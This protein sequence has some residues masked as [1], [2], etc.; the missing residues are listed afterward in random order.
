MLALL[1]LNRLLVPL[2]WPEPNDRVT[3]SYSTFKD[4]VMAHNVAEIIVQGEAIQGVFKQPVADAVPPA[5]QAPRT[6]TTF[7]T[8]IPPFAANENLAALLEQQGVQISAKAFDEGRSTPLTFLLSFGPALLLLGGVF[9]LSSRGSGMLHFGR[10]RA[11][12]YDTVEETQRITFADV[13]GIDEVKHELADIVDFLRQPEK[14]QRLGGTIPKGV[15]LVG[16]PGTGKTLL[17][18]AVAGE[19][20]VPFFSMGGSEFIEMIVGV[21][22][23]RVRDLFAEAKK[24]APAIV[25]V[26]ELDAIGRRRGSAVSPSY[27]KSASASHT[28]SR[29]TPCWAC[30]SPRAIPCGA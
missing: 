14:Y 24:A 23:S 18:R 2:L 10:S 4:Q 7:A 22:A 16:P 15:L 5:G 1:L 17:A 29:A 12:R 13:A 19:A 11:K 27:R 25:F 21:G 26:D 3:V 28:T 8:R 9:W 30:C 20:N 6:Y